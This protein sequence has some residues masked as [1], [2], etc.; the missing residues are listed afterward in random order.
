MMEDTTAPLK[1]L[2]EE[3]E[4][5][6]Q[7]LCSTPSTSSRSA[8]S[9][10]SWRSTSS[11]QRT[12]S[13]TA[14]P[15][16]GVRTKRTGVPQPAPKEPEPFKTKFAYKKG[17][18]NPYSH[19]LYDYFFS[20]MTDTKNPRAQCLIIK[21][22]GADGT[23]EVC[24]TRLK[25]PRNWNSPASKHL[26]RM[27]KEAFAE[28]RER[29]QIY[30]DLKKLKKEMD[31]STADEHEGR[32]PGK[33]A[34]IEATIK[35]R[36]IVRSQQQLQFDMETVEFLV[37]VGLPWTLAEHP[38]FQTY[39]LR[40]D[41]R[42][43]FK[44]A[45]TYAQAKMPLLFKQVEDT[46]LHKLRKDIKETEGVAF[47]ADGWTSPAPDKYIGVTIHYINK[48]WQMEHFVVACSPQDGQSTGSI[49]A[50][51][52][53]KTVENI[54]VD[55]NMFKALTTDNTIFKALDTT[56][57]SN[58]VDSHLRCFDNTLQLIVNS[59]L[60]TKCIIHALNSCKNLVSKTHVSSK[61]NEY[62]LKETNKLNSFATEGNPKVAYVKFVNCNEIGLN[63]CLM[64]LRSIIRMKPVLNKIRQSDNINVPKGLQENIPS[65]EDLDIVEGILPVLTEF[66]TI[67]DFM[68]RENYPTINYVVGKL[69]QLEDSLKKEMDRAVSDEAAIFCNCLI[70]NLAQKF[71]KNGTTTLLYA[72][73]SLLNPSIL[74]TIL[75][76]H[77]QTTETFESMLEDE[78]R[79]LPEVDELNEGKI[80]EE[81]DE[82]DQLLLLIKKIKTPGAA[83]SLVSIPTERR[84]VRAELMC[85]LREKE[86]L[87][88]VKPEDQLKWWMQREHK[89]PNLCKIVK[90]LF[91]IQATS[92]A[93]E[94]TFSIDGLIV[95]PKLEPESVHKLV[96]IR[97]NM[98][99]LIMKDLILS[100]AEEE[101]M[102]QCFEVK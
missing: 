31:Q 45:A 60:K 69:Y 90:K 101:A 75:N 85:Y 74:D 38:A 21:K 9:S 96:F 26:E 1:A 93:V 102:E 17:Y 82:T 13:V 84:P 41:P 42:V 46:L 89:F 62:L 44:C 28:F 56:K 3:M 2:V 81:E 7:E 4:V 66:E 65:V 99:K 10:T 94:R 76:L 40:R 29:L 68:S 14:K 63:S 86:S 6:G 55:D 5:E 49:I 48:N 27:H 87:G 50:N 25:Q 95:T 30:N 61:I 72:Q 47:T 23:I 70:K 34:R 57:I 67:T 79:S 77:S 73:A 33:R 92:C 64:M 91:C 98:P 24:G 15:S 88:K 18:I 35:E 58:Q 80:E 19:P 53:E 83:N 32:T 39:L 51:L 59:A 71:P 20:D 97:E 8:P 78:E 52:F 37:Q 100:N 16:A 12:S 54:E 11:I 22:K 43:N 36:Y